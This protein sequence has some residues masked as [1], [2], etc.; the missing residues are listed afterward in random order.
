[1]KTYVLLFRSITIC[2][3]LL[4]FNLSGL[5]Q[6]GIDAPIASKKPSKYQKQQIKRK[7]G[8]FIHFGINTFHDEE[9]TDGSKP[10][11][12]YKPT[13]IDAKQWVET[14]KK[15]GMKYIILVAKHHDGFC[16]WDSK[17][18]EY[19]VANS[20]NTTN[21]VEAIAK[22]CKAQGIDLG[23]YYSLWDR[24]ENADTKNPDLDNAY[25]KYMI[26]QL[27]EL[28][29]IAQKHTKVVELWLDAGWEKPN[30]RWPINDI[31]L[32]IK[33]KAPQC[34]IGINWSI[35]LPENVDFHAVYP[36]DQKEGYPIRYFPSDFRLGDPLLPVNPDPK[37]FSHNDKL[38]YMPFE[39]T[40]CIS[41]NWFYN[42]KDN[43]YKSID[44]LVELYNIAT[45]Q[46]NILILNLP[47]NRE[48]KMRDK[49]V[50]LLIELRKKLK[51]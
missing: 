2:I 42:T 12:S 36:K 19:D 38:Y 21:V 18:T 32:T 48:G 17:Y 1:M 40:I 9:W 27:N 24:K 35:G 33:T 26:N 4:S 34:Q 51:L 50:E 14:A 20:G 46:D 47:P 7:Y 15:A 31:Y 30:Y 41:D 5:A 23:L 43:K 13:T 25:N 10:A 39:S 49:D 28:I 16:L 45:A 11:S 6:K 44:K 29:D 3:C 8:M 37:L 22:E